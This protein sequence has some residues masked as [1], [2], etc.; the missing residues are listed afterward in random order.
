MFTTILK[1]EIKHWLKQPSIYIYGLILFGMA[2][3]VTGGMAAEDTSRFA[4]RILNSPTYLL[5]MTKRLMLVILFMLPAIIGVTVYRDFNTNMYHLLF[6]YPFQKRAYLFGK[7]ISAFLVLMGIVL[8]L[9]IGYATG[10]SMP[11]VNPELVGPS[12]PIMYIQLYA[13]FLIPK[14]FLISVLVFSIVLLSRNIYSGFIVVFFLILLNQIPATFSWGGE[15]LFWKTLLDP[16]GTDAIGHYTKYW[17]KADEN[18]NLLPMGP[19]VI[20]NRLLWLG[21]SFL[22]FGLTYRYFQFHQTALNFNRKKDAE[23]EHFIFNLGQLTK[24]NLTSVKYN[25][26]FSQQCNY[27]WRMSNI[28]FKYIVTSKPFF[29]LVLGGLIALMVLM[30]ASN[31]LWETETYPLTWQMLQVPGMGFSGIINAITFLYAGLLIHRERRFQMNQLVDASPIPNWALLGSKLLALIKI[32]MVLLFLV[33][34]GGIVVQIS[35]GYYNFEIGQYLFNLYGMNLIHFIIWAL[36]ALFVQTLLKNPYLG[37]FLLVFVPIGMIG[38]SEFGQNQLGIPILEQGIFRY[39]QGPGEIRGLLYSDLDAYGGQLS[40]YFIY[41]FYWLLGG[42]LFFIGALLL[43]KRG[44]NN[45]S[46]SALGLL[47]SLK[48]TFAERLKKMRTR[49]TGKTRLGFVSILLLFVSL[50]FTIFHDTNISHDFYS[51]SQR[52]KILDT[53]EKKYRPYQNFNQPKIVDVK[54]NMDVFP[55]ERQFKSDGKYIVVNLSDQPIDT[56]TINY[57]GG[58]NLTYDF[59]QAY[60]FHSQEAIGNVGNFDILVLKK[61]LLPGD[62]LQMSFNCNSD[63]TTLLRGQTMV[64]HD[65]TYIKDDIFP[66]LGNYIDYIREQYGMRS[67]VRRPHPSDSTATFESFMAKD[68]DRMGFEATIST[69]AN[70]IGIAPGHLEKH[71]EENGRNYYHYKMDEKIASSWLFMSG[72]YAIAKD[73]WRDV[74]LE[75][76]YNKKHPYNIDRMMRGMKNSLEYCSENF[77]PYQHKHL[78]IVEFSQTGARSAH[79]FPGTIPAGEGTGFTANVDDSPEGGVDYAYGVAVHETAHEWWGHQ[80]LPANTRG[81]KMITEGMAD[82]VNTKVKEHNLGIEEARKFLRYNMDLYFVRRRHDHRPEQPLIYAYHNQ[83]Y[84]HYC[85]GAQVFFTLADYIGEKNLNNAIK[86]YVE[87]VAF[88]EVQYT[89]SL[90][91]L[92]FIRTA[93]PDSLDYLI[94]DMFET[95][96]LHQNTMK[97]WT[98]T[99]LDNGQFQVDMEFHV[100]KYRNIKY[101]EKLYSDN[102]IDSLR[103]QIPN[104]DQSIFSLP[105]NDYMEVGIFGKDKKEIYLRKHKVNTIQNKL[106]IVVD[107]NPEEVAIDPYHLFIDHELEDNWKRNNFE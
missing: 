90:E 43:W 13:L 23:K 91:M 36:L 85:K 24:V 54:I 94:K 73:K 102:G 78:R 53:A 65:G 64:K 48:V 98:V 52:N 104:S 16:L 93:V 35:K 12:R 103:Y 99:P 57:L 19:I 86:A 21:I 39:N 33:M 20:F 107:E 83:N 95:V 106:T 11:W 1:Y 105:L 46:N 40:A 68:A 96:T 82:Y 75:I 31:R 77:S 3:L 26:S 89:T 5:N 74:D 70:Q 7:F 63:P 66:R 30:A 27:M 59:D 60:D 80:I 72:E 4:G 41:K 62:S 34:L 49:F 84:I 8:L 55:E 71:W 87:K 29:A 50:G 9:G 45:L 67:R 81:S 14:I 10:F 32:Q 58:N 28:D 17:T 37:F 6:A 44:V 76:F 92:D 101:G 18:V 2:F 79:G 15:G 97:D 42:A 100:S 47:A 69:A 38:L 88:Q 25:F 22:I 61:S 56:L 51:R